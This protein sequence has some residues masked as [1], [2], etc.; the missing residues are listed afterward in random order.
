MREEAIPAQEGGSCTR[1]HPPTRQAAARK[2]HPLETR[3]SFKGLPRT[4]LHGQKRLLQEERP[5][6]VARG[7]PLHKRCPGRRLCT[8]GFSA[9]WV[10]V[11]LGAGE[12]LHLD[13]AGADS[14]AD[15]LVML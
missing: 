6:T 12:V 10:E 8:R 15:V 4:G 9:P 14:E 5:E 7:G 1:K 3:L 2:E 13:G 11:S